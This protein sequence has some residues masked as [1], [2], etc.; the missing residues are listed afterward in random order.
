MRAAIES[1]VRAEQA[2]ERLRRE[3]SHAEELRILLADRERIARDLHD[4]AIQELFAAGLFLEFTARGAPEEIRAR[5][6]EVVDQL[7]NVIRDIR[8]AIFGLTD[9]RHG[10]S[11]LAQSIAVVAESARMLGFR[12]TFRSSGPID[13]AGPNVAEHLVPT[14]R[15]AL[16]NVARHARATRVEI[17]L[18]HGDGRLTLRVADNGVGLPG[19]PCEEGNGIHNVAERARELGG[20]MT[21]EANA[22]HGCT[23]VWSIPL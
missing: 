4:T 23:M 12:P 6:S 14:L 18:D 2:V 3:E 7:D 1:A 16:S 5:L 15:E 19:R 22:E 13:L 20:T 9:R 10:E 8:T 21:L 11:P 17:N